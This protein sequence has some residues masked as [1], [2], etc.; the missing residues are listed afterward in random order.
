LLHKTPYKPT[1]DLALFLNSDLPLDTTRFQVLY[2]TV[3]IYNLTGSLTATP[4]EDL[5]VTVTLGQNYYR[6][7]NEEKA[8]HLPSFNTNISARYT[9]LAN[10]LVLKAE[11][12]FENGV[13]YKNSVSDT[14][15]ARH[16][17]GLV[18]LNLGAEYRIVKNI[19]VFIDFNNLASNNRERW[20]RYPTYGTNLVGGITARF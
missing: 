16:L 5:E 9:T 15:D 4:I 7:K 3:D 1:D 11:F 14:S 18:D 17:N 19:G 2:D 6:P 8:W 20:H 13:P 12:Y 10:K